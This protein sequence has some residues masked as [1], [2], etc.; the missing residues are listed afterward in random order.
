MASDDRPIGFID[1]GVGGLT[2][3]RAVRRLL[4]RESTL[5]VA[6]QAYFPYGDKPEAELQLRAEYLSRR[7]M[8]KG[9]K[10]IVVACNA[11]SV[12]AL[13]HLRAVFPGF[14]FVGV[15]PVIKTLAR[16]TRSGV[17]GLLC[18]PSTAQSP[19]TRMLADEFAAER[20]LIVVPCPGLA[21]R[22]E[23]GEAASP[24]TEALLRRLLEPL[25]A[26]GADAVGLGCTHYPLARRAIK[27]VLGPGVRVYEPSRPVARRVR[28]LLTQMDALSTAPAPRH[29]L[30]TTGRPQQLQK[31]LDRLRW[32]Q[33]ATAQEL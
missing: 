1:S 31:V 3:L 7:L 12:G 13:A 20:R 14:P 24:A 33:G 30:F 5:Y 26:A 29:Q 21:D 6:D 28:Q 2:I 22:I 32:L 27:R 25:L 10:L 17:I 19:Y 16:V 8:E 11:A 15:V 4:P 18:T 23:L 9:A